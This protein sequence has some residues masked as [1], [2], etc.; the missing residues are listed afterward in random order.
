[1]RL[2][3]RNYLP[4]MLL[5]LCISCE[6]N[7][8]EVSAKYVMLPSFQTVE[9]NSVFDVFLIQDS[10]YAIEVVGHQEI[11]TNVV[12]N[13][14]DD[15]L[16]VSN[17]SGGKWL[18]PKKNKVKLYIH[19]D[20][21]S[22]IVP[23]ETCYI[24]TINPI[25]S[26]AFTIVMGHRPKLAEIDLEL[27]CGTF[28]Y[29]NNHQCGGKLTLAGKTG[30]LSISSFALMSVDA[31]ELIANDATV[32]NSSKGDCTVRVKDE[33]QY[34][35]HGVGNIYVYGNPGSVIPEAIT[36]TGQLILLD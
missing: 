9:L 30:H 8:H 11:I 17:R 28:L 6:D 29:W 22:Q 14:E 18:M 5:S 27:N 34:S 2:R 19:S 12:Y 24:K 20:R 36:S 33:I 21:L 3:I 35:I 15:T 32:N 25:I 7:T 26:D 1:M 31:S 10:I 16:R 4:F 23:N 13:V